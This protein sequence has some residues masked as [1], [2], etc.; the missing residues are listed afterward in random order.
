MKKLLII[1]FATLTTAIHVT[2]QNDKQ[3]NTL[4]DTYYSVR[5]A[6][7]KGDANTSS[8]RAGE[9]SRHAEG[10]KDAATRTLLSQLATE[11]RQLSST[12]DLARQRESF[13]NLSNTMIRLVKEVKPGTAGIH[14][15]YCPMKKA[16]WLSADQVIKNPYYGSS[17][18]TCGKISETIK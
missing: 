9:L 3:A 16:Y 1:L 7:V 11:A 15:A 18:L 4:L 14:V 17:M 6:L 10:L 13:S 12:K 2:A 5:D 8:T